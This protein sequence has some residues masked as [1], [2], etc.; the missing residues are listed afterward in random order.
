MYKSK[1]KLILFEGVFIVSL[2]PHL[3]LVLQFYGKTRMLHVMHV[4]MVYVCWS[5]SLHIL[6]KSFSMLIALIFVLFSFFRNARILV[7]EV[8]IKFLQP[9]SS[10]DPAGKQ[11]VQY[12][13]YI[14]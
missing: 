13:L 1:W 14:C 9:S 2:P 8:D 12:C 11:F 3:L 4:L 10:S 5:P 7:Q 6:Y